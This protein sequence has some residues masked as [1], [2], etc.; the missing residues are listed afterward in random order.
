MD[1]DELENMATNFFRNLYTREEGLDPSVIINR[2]HVCG[3]G[4]MNDKLCA[5]FSE[6]EIGDA[7]FQIG[8]LK[9]PRPDGFPARFMQ[10]NWG[11]LKEDVVAAVQRFFA[12]GRMPDN[13][14]ETSIVLIPKKDN[15]TV[16]RNL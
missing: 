16:Q 13:V 1:K 14:N 11:L 7:L 8:P 4:N 12:K 6:K 2:M 9:A 5:P 3:D 10:R 15:P